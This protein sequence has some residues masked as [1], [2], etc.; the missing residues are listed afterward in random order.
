MPSLD[1]KQISLPSGFKGY[2]KDN[3]LK[4]EVIF[5][6][7]NFQC[8]PGNQHPH[9]FFPS[10]PSLAVAEMVAE[11]HGYQ[12]DTREDKPTLVRNDFVGGRC[13]ERPPFRHCIWNTDWCSSLNTLLSS[14]RQEP[15]VSINSISFTM[16]AF[17][18]I[19]INVKL[20]TVIYL[21]SSWGNQK[22]ND[23][24]WGGATAP[25]SNSQG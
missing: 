11:L 20:S 25:P 19:W 4:T 21:S 9:S 14:I 18:F 5:L 7:P 16:V 3:T 2:S 13:F 23:G 17:W 22:S 1:E 10:L 8:C 15:T 12:L 24:R 6:T